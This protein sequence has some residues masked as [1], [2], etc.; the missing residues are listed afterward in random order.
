MSAA[1][2]MPIFASASVVALECERRHEER[3]GEPDSGD[4]AAADDRRPA[5]R[6]PQAPA[7]QPGREPA[8]ARD[9]DRLADDVADDDPER[10][11]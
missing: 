6:R 11:R 7:R 10:H 2:M 8:D 3:D 4:R 9:A 1:A 5:H